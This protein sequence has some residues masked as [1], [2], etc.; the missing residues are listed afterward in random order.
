M[1]KEF[2]MMV[3]GVLSHFREYYV[4]QHQNHSGPRYVPIDLS[5][6]SPEVRERYEALRL[7]RREHSDRLGFPPYAVFTN[8]ALLEIS[9]SNPSELSELPKINGVGETK[10]AR[11]GEDVLR[12]LSNLA[13]AAPRGGEAA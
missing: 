5:A 1:E 10:T 13:V 8:R 7:W 9:Q 6:V 4:Q 2:E 12:I 3:E 11:F